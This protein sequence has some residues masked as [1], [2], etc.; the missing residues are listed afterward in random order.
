V[1]DAVAL[2][3]GHGLPGGVVEGGQGDRLEVASLEV[4]GDADDFAVDHRH[5]ALDHVLER[6]RVDQAAHLRRRCHPARG[7]AR[8][9]ARE[10][11]C[12]RRR[13]GAEDVARVQA[14]PDGAQLRRRGAQGVRMGGEEGGIDAACRDAADDRE[15]Q[16]RQVARDAAQ[17]PRLVGAAR[18]AAG[19]HDGEAAGVRRV[20]GKGAG[21]GH[22]LAARSGRRGPT[23]LI[24]SPRGR[25][26][27]G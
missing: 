21:L 25:F 8:H 19:E 22:R 17:H 7:Q 6:P 15:A 9:P 2:H 13:I 26:G 27:V 20:A 14:P 1:L 24:G 23:L 4:V 10:M 5:G 3:P 18:A 11:P 12:Q 16:L